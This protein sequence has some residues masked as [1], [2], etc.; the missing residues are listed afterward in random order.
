M[1][2]DPLSAVDM[3]V[4]TKMFNQGICG[5]AKDT[6]RVLV[7][8]SHLHLLRHV[9]NIIIMEG[10]TIGVIGSFEELSNNPN[11]NTLLQSALANAEA[12][13]EDV[14]AEDGLTKPRYH[15]SFSLM[16]ESRD[17]VDDEKGK[18]IEE[19]DREYGMQCFVLFLCFCWSWLCMYC[20]W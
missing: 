20:T 15:T 11:H 14:Q 9:D 4:G 12:A 17:N 10:G 16:E 1:F 7:M 8:N 2:D 3:E 5:V 6:T 13:K 18:L 19:E